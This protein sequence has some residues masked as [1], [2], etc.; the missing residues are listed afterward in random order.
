MDLVE[1]LDHLLIEGD[2][3]KVQ[4]YIFKRVWEDEIHLS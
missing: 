1:T 3:R 2:P 4:I